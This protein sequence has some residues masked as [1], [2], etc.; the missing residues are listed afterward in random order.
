[1]LIDFRR[2]ASKI[3]S[4]T[5]Q[6]MDIERVTTYKYLGV[7]LNNKLDWSNNTEALYKK[8][9]TRLHLLRRLRSLGS[10]SYYITFCLVYL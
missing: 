4:V 5:I 7:H 10:L 3:T 2:K 6:D 9:Q 1:M 8:G